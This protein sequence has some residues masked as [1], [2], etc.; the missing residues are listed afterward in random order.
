M[1]FFPCPLPLGRLAQQKTNKHDD[2]NAGIVTFLICSANLVADETPVLIQ[3]GVTTMCAK[4]KI[5]LSTL[6][7]VGF[8]SIAQAGKTPKSKKMGDRSPYLSKTVQ[9]PEGTAAFGYVGPRRSSDRSRVPSGPDFSIR[10][11]H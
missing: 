2:V 3:I 5:A 6:L 8:A 1:A 4:T 9:R 10:S 7:V 11:Q